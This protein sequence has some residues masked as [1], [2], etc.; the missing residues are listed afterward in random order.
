MKNNQSF[1]SR[2]FSHNITLLV[3]AFVLAFSA[4]LVINYND[5]TDTDITV[6]NIP[7]EIELPESAQNAG[8]KLFRADDS[9]ATVTVRGNRTTIASITSSDVK[10]TANQTSRMTTAGTYTLDLVGKPASI[11]SNF[12]VVSVDPAEIKCVVDRE[13]EQEF[14]IENQISVEL[15]DKSLYADVAFSPSKVV[16]SGPESQVSKIASVAVIDSI[17]S[18]QISSDKPITEELYFLD[19]DGNK[20]TDLDMV[21]KDVDSVETSI[22]VQPVKNVRLTVSPVNAPSGAPSATLSPTTVKI[23]GPEE[24]LNSIE[25]NTV[26]IGT[27]DFSK[28]RNTNVQQKYNITLPNGCKVISGGTSSTLSIDLSSYEGTTVNAK[29]TTSIDTSKYSADLATD[30]V[31]ITIY[32]PSSTLSELTTS[33]ISVVADFSGLLDDINNKAV[34]L[35][36]PLKVSLGDSFGDCWVYGSYTINANVSKK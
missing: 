26:N 16:V 1:L 19:E 7:I 10:V 33:D 11:T 20:L 13:S 36:V 9:K 28:L 22:T 5:D 6:D 3:L 35:S 32:G 27:L 18:K 8:L 15:D 31:D 2:F 21:K 34:S 17:T 23:T 4:W 14:D 24:T 25:N 29:I 30:D 12:D